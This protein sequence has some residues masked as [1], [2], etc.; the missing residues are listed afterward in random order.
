MKRFKLY[1]LVL[2]V[3]FSV[4]AGERASQPAVNAAQQADKT[5]TGTGARKANRL[6]NSSSPYLLQHAYNPVDWYPWGEEAFAQ[7]RKQN[8]PI[9]L[10]IGYSTCHWC[11]VM[12]RESFEN[13]KIAALL[14]KYFIC[15]KVDR[16]ER[17]DIDSVYM[18]ATQLINGHGGWPMTVF[19]DHRLRPFHAA[20]YYPPFTT[21]KGP[22]LED[23]LLKVHQ[24]W[25]K[26]PELIEENA[27]QVTQQIRA[28]ADDTRQQ[29]ALADDINEQ[30][31]REIVS[32]YDDGFGGFSAAPKFP[33]PGIFSFLNGLSLQ[34]S[35]RPQ[36]QDNKKSAAQM[37][38]T[39]LDAMAD[40]GI[41]DHIG[42]G[43]HR[44][45][46]DD[47]WQVPHFEKMLYTQALMVIAYSDFYRVSPS[48][49][50]KQV[51]A[52]TLDFVLQDMRAAGGGF[53]SALDA[54]SERTDKPGEHGEGAYYLWSEA[55]L[56][57]RLSADEFD[58]AREYFHV[59]EQGNIYSDP[60]NEFE[61]LNVLYVDEAF[62]GETLS[63]QQIEWLD[64]IRGK[65]E[66]IRHQRPMPHLDDKVIT[67]WNGM[68]ITALAK[69]SRVFNNAQWQRE[70]INSIKFIEENLYDSDSNKLL[71][72][73][74]QKQADSEGVLADYVWLIS[75][76]L[77][78]YRNDG[79]E[80]W[81]QRAVSLQKRQDEL[82]LDKSS[83]AYFE[84]TANDASLLFRFKSI[85][86]DALPSANAIALSNLRMLSALAARP[87]QKK[88]WAAQAEQLVRSFAAAVNRYPSGAA[89]LL[90]VELKQKL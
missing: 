38:R 52:Q 8:K 35:L 1:L 49:K 89:M 43:F 17:P 60:R 54:D 90:S 7:A 33:R 11:H 79:D 80:Q 36:K 2:L 15:I 37:M 19:L 61:N 22:G 72:H 24:L 23:I 12:A 30:A 39:T 9:F 69:A 50:Y 63:P 65:L 48:Q 47:S 75:G 57:K 70:A 25:T 76:L 27:I 18:A 34:S 85:Y 29:A 51:V 71:R 77:A 5:H 53:Y 58:F 81:L 20:T 87:A 45:A 13:E 41:F 82:F 21:D 10:S 78:V 56:K 40:G 88:A 74:R 68:M 67:A 16:E 31:L 46:V 86:D 14:N 59:R 84:S 3:S 42:G 28:Y 4:Q 64:S 83:G 55:E 66:K 6:I 44:Y 73:Y 62:R 26:Q 32:I